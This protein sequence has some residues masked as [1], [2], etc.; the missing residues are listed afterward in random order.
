M[1]AYEFYAFTHLELEMKKPLYVQIVEFISSYIREHG[2]RRGAFKEAAKIFYPR[3]YEE[4]P[5]Y[6]VKLVYEHFRY[7]RRQIGKRI[8]NEVFGASGTGFGAS[9]SIDESVEMNMGYYVGNHSGPI[10]ESKFA[11]D[12][13]ADRRLFEFKK[14]VYAVLQDLVKPK[15]MLTN[16]VEKT[17]SDPRVRNIL[18]NEDTIWYNGRSYIKINKKQAALLYLVVHR[19]YV[20]HYGS[21]NKPEKLIKKYFEITGYGPKDLEN[22]IKELLPTFYD[23]LLHL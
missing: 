13:K 23:W 8:W 2:S 5:R 9:D 11:K 6:A 1:S 20:R 21:G 4:N 15:S 12:S 16:Y 18:D 19:I 14:L 17:L 3:I 10:H 7:A 22:E